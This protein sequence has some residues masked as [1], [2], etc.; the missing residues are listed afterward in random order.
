MRRSTNLMVGAGILGIVIGSAVFAPQIAPHNPIDQAFPDQLRAPSPV[1]LFGTD[2]FGRDIFSRVVY[3]ARIAL[4]AGVLADGIAAGL[5]IL[6]GITSGYFGRRVDAAIM[7]SVDV[8]LAFPYLLLAMIVVAILGPSLVNAMIAIGI[9]YTPQFARLV[10]GAVLAIREQEFV[11]AAGA[12][13]A[14]APRILARHILPNI[15]S[16]IIVMATLTVGFTIV[17]TAGLSFLG[18]GAS[19]PTPEWG[20]MLATGRSFMLTAPWIATFPGLAILITVVGFN[21][22]GDGLRDLLD[23]RLR[24]RH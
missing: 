24:G 20:S 3:G 15:L 11:E 13:G 2:E 17:E 6:L 19:P 8:L 23:P 21:L 12:V 9:V 14:G 1:H 5:G 7:R 4:V 18:L 16:P 22:V 10:R